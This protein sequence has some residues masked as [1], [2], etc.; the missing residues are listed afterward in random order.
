[1]TVP[2]QALPAAS[3][4][5]SLA[6]EAMRR[7]LGRIGLGAALRERIIPISL[8]R[9]RLTIGVDGDTKKAIAWAR[10]HA[11][12]RDIVAVPLATAQVSATLREL[13]AANASPPLSR[14]EEQIARAVTTVAIGGGSDLFALPDQTGVRLIAK[15]NGAAREISRMDSATYEQSLIAGSVSGHLGGTAHLRESQSCGYQIDYDAV[16]VSCRLRTYPRTIRIGTETKIVPALDFRIHPDQDDLPRPDELGIR[17]EAIAAL[18]R[19]LAEERLPVLVSGEPGVGKTT[20][21]FSIL[22]E[23]AKVWPF[24][25]TFEAP[26][27]MVVDELIQREVPTISDAIPDREAL[28]QMNPDIVFIGEALGRGSF[29]PLLDFIET[30]VP[31]VT[32]LHERT[33]LGALYRAVQLGGDRYL[34]KARLIW[35]QALIAPVCHNCGTQGSPSAAVE[36]RFKLHETPP[37]TTTWRRTVGA[38]CAYCQG[39]GVTGPRRPLVEFFH[40]NA[41][42]REVVRGGAWNPGALRKLVYPSPEGMTIAGSG[43]EALRAGEIDETEFLRLGDDLV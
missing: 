35:C 11:G 31:S 20:T 25:Y 15:I 34:T 10:V 39:L 22:R 21:L 8:A 40:V 13:R 33:A 5:V 38:D 30:N 4:D 26:I 19:V 32:T 24:I 41:G 2:E 12:L 3:A 28:L 1:M 43:A 27:E 36:Y 37:P 29:A 14:A 9:G 23:I 6:P 17:A 7:A 16:R 18:R 42:V